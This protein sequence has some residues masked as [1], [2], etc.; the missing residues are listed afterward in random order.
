MF[1]QYF[2]VDI[3]DCAGD[4][5]IGYK[6][7]NGKHYMYESTPMNYDAAVAECGIAGATPAMFKTKKELQ[8]LQFLFGKIL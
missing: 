5:P 7:I 1:I 2:L 6:L 4:L 3:L 8:A